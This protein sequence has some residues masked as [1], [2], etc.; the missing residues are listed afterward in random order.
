MVGYFTAG[1]LMLLGFVLIILCGKET[2]LCYVGGSVFVLLGIWWLLDTMYPDHPIINGWVG[3]VVKG[4]AAAALVLLGVYYFVFRK[5]EVTQFQDAK[6]EKRTTLYDTYDDFQY[7]EEA[8]KTGEKQ[9]KQSH[10]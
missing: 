5:R 6:T 1:I 10:P 3:W 7:D 9:T 2:K 4:I 8:E